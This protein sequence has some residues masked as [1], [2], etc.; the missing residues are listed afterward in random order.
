MTAEMIT[1]E[2]LGKERIKG[3]ATL[4]SKPRQQLNEMLWW[5]FETTMYISLSINLNEATS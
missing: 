3:V 5:D 2:F 4:Q 1:K